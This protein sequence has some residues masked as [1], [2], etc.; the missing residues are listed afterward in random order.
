MGSL[1]LRG[2]S[3]VWSLGFI[4]LSLIFILSFISCLFCFLRVKFYFL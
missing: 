1:F 4:F 2:F 3:G